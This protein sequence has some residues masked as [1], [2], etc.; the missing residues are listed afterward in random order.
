MLKERK[1]NLIQI[2]R[3]L[4]LGI[5]CLTLVFSSLQ[6][7]GYSF[8]RRSVIQTLLLYSFFFH[9][10]ERKLSGK[11][12]IQKSN[13][14]LPI[15]ILL[16]LVTVLIYFAWDT[17]LAANAV[18]HIL[19]LVCGFY[20][21][22]SVANRREEQRWLVV[23]TV[24]VTLW[25]CIYG[26]LIH[27]KIYLFPTWKYINMFQRGILSSTFANHNHFAGWLEMSILFYISLFFIKTRSKPVIVFML[28]LMV[29]MVVTMVLTLSRGGWI[30]LCSGGMF[31]LTV[32]GFN[33][34][35]SLSKRMLFFITSVGVFLMLAA[36]GSTSVIERGMT[37]AAHQGD[38]IPGRKIMWKGAMDMIGSFPL[39]GVGP[40]NYSTAAALFNPP[41]MNILYSDAHNDYLQF[42]SE[43]GILIIPIM[44][45]MIVSLFSHG[46]KKLQ[47]PSRQT[48]WITL[49]SMAGVV[50]IMV[51]SISDFNLQFPS[52]ALFFTALAA[53]VA[54]PAP[55]LKKMS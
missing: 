15:L 5:I 8:W 20:V 9:I 2:L 33:K 32:A 28:F 43:A 17:S 50:A 42:A 1:N 47:H 11:N 24:A 48:R 51:H 41:G 7:G 25:L 37:M 29:I 30:A 45:W 55:T 6:D 38:L 12:P 4:S 18:I 19:S 27:F 26:L 23:L 46:F 22:I 31:I 10:L 3:Y 49:A 36:L 21:F 16:C 14:N 39:T 34:R 40:G 52:N 44:L 54:A 35:F 13:L 53:Q